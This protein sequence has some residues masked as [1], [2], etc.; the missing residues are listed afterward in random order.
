M[1]RNTEFENELINIPKI[2][3]EVADIYF[4]VSSSRSQENSFVF[5][6]Q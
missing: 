1:L 6:F 5:L 3:K 2:L 4:I